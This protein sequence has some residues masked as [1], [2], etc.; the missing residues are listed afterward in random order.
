MASY[1]AQV[2]LVNPGHYSNGAMY[3]TGDVV[4]VYELVKEKPNP[5]GRLGFVHVH[6]VPES[7]NLSRLTKELSR[8]KTI[9]ATN[10]SELS[11]RRAWSIELGDLS[12]I[13]K[14]VNIEWADAINL[15]TRKFDGKSG[16]EYYAELST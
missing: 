15:F 1:T 3:C 7:I 9:G 14:E 5:N 2:M 10:Q 8:P 11:K 6:N 13:E 16:A 4:A 12:I